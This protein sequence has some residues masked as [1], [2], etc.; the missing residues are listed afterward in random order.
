MK[1]Y[2][3]CGRATTNFVP[4][5]TRLARKTSSTPASFLLPALTTTDTAVSLTKK[6]F[7]RCRSLYFIYFKWSFPVSFSLSSSFEQL[8]VK[9]W[10]LKIA[11]GWIRTSFRPWKQPLYQV[12]TITGQAQSC[13][14]S[15]SFWSFNLLLYSIFCFLQNFSVL[16]MKTFFVARVARLLS[17]LDY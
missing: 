13:F 15:W 2:F 6:M 12:L 7:M 17:A 11:D 4:V 5:N 10:S 1:T 9:I 3:I 16:D 14:V 8:T